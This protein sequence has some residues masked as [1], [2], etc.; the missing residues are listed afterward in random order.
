MILD[1]I[2]LTTQD[3]LVI[4]PGQTGALHVVVGSA[5][6][7]T[8][9]LT[10]TCDVAIIEVGTEVTLIAAPSSGVRM[11]K[12]ISVHNADASAADF[13]LGVKRSGTVYK[14]ASVST[15]AADATWTSNQADA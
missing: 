6:K 1:T 8:T 10:P 13:V 7:N 11:I 2:V 12:S 14:L 5:I 3:S 4:V 9:G 15:L